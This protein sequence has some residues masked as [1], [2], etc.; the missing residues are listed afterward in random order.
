MWEDKTEIENRSKRFTFHVC[1]L[2]I[3]VVI[4][5]LFIK[6]RQSLSHANKSRQMHFPTCDL[7]ANSLAFISVAFPRTCRSWISVKVITFTTQQQLM[8]LQSGSVSNHR[9]GKLLQ[10]NNRH[11]CCWVSRR[12]QEEEEKE[13]CCSPFPEL[14]QKYQKGRHDTSAYLGAASCVCVCFWSEKDLTEAKIQ[15]AGKCVYRSRVS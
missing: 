6:G 3:L 14:L 12:G 8:A 1:Y 11:W 9:S 10:K 5:C 7:P 2:V 13:R 15:M 4:A